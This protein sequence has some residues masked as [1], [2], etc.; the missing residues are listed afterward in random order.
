MPSPLKS[1]TATAR[2]WGPAAYWGAVIKPAVR[3]C[4]RRTTAKRRAEPNNLPASISL[5]RGLGS[6]RTRPARAVRKEVVLI[7]RLS[8]YLED[9]S[10]VRSLRQIVLRDHLGVRT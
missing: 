5:P 4:P 8:H 6:A 10:P 3:R 9:A 2:G 7:G 1:P